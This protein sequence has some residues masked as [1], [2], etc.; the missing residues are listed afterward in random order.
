MI[1]SCRPAQKQKGRCYKA[2]V[3]LLFRESGARTSRVTKILPQPTP[4][5]RR[6]LQGQ[7][8][9]FQL[10]LNLYGESTR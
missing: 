3:F 8:L 4:R 7:L 5:P 6:T 9:T 1:T 2:T 10:A